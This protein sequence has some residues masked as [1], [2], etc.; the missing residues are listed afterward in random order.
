MEKD[1]KCKRHSKALKMY[2]E[3]CKEFICSLCLELH[4]D[5][6][7]KC[8]VHISSYMKKTLLPKYGDA[9]KS[10]E[11]RKGSLELFAKNLKASAAEIL[12]GLTS[13]RLKLSG[14][15]GAVDESLQILSMP[16][17][18]LDGAYSTSR[19][20]TEAEYAELTKAI[21][22][23]RVEYLIKKASENIN[24]D[25]AVVGDGEYRFIEALEKNIKALLDLKEVD[26][27]TDGLRHYQNLYKN[28]L[29]Q[30]RLEVL[31]DS[32]YG[33]CKLISESKQLCRYDIVRKS[34]ET[35]I[36]VP[37][38]CTATQIGTRVFLS[39]G[40]KP[41]TNAVSEYVESDK[42][43]IP[44]A[45]MTYAKFNHTTEVIST[46]EF[47]AIG[48]YNGQ[49]MKCCEKYNT[50]DDE[51]ALLPELNIP[52]YGLGSVFMQ[53]TY[54][55]AIG[56]ADEKNTVELLDLSQ[57][58]FWVLLKL[59]QCEVNLDYS[60]KA[61]SASPHEA[62]MF[63]GGEERMGIFDT[64]EKTVRR[65]KLATK[66]DR[67]NFNSLCVVR[68]HAY[69]IGNGYGHLHDYSFKDNKLYDMDLAQIYKV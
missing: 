14:L 42:R 54:L 52:R 16:L 45:E 5:K 4:A 46:T 33:V 27:L 24:I 56:G 7:C 20:K 64:R 69:V 17:V 66:V 57:N 58:R 6:G 12:K 67:Y 15:L 41:V 3:S 44:G 63:C 25:I 68:E 53:N 38:R 37:C 35:L 13:L 34:L 31:S 62:I 26:S 21:E 59:K 10:L 51:W 61:F 29:D 65:S 19:K 43:L 9:L 60:L 8:P 22:E 39:G 55:Y 48:G 1:S 30:G 18:S 28:F 40:D 32:V 11:E 36:A 2:C 23:N 50:G 47:V 49:A